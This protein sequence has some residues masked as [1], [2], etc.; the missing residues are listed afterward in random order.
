MRLYCYQAVSRMKR[1]I[2]PQ[3]WVSSLHLKP[4]IILMLF[5]LKVS[6]EDRAQCFWSQGVETDLPLFYL[7][8]CLPTRLFVWM[9]GWMFEST[10][11]LVKIKRQFCVRKLAAFFFNCHLF[12]VTLFTSSAQL[13]RTSRIYRINITYSCVTAPPGDVS[14]EKSRFQFP[15]ELKIMTHLYCRLLEQHN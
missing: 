7:F 15:S 5:K 2:K 3:L 9:D 11:N 12:P 13:S 8:C 14:C 10:V 6:S 4:I 1:T